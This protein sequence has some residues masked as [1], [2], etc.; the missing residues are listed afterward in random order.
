MEFAWT[1]DFLGGWI[2]FRY[3]ILND[4]EIESFST[5]TRMFF[6]EATE[7]SQELQQHLSAPACR[8]RVEAF[9]HSMSTGAGGIAWNGSL[10]FCCP[11]HVVILHIWRNSWIFSPNGSTQSHCCCLLKGFQR[12]THP[13]PISS[14]HVRGRRETTGPKEY[15][16]I[17][18]HTKKLICTTCECAQATA[19]CV[20]LP[21][22]PILV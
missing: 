5:K 15:T 12:H 7:Q 1:W 3:T 18:T 17:V 14:E 11:G 19:K 9:G 2:A 16:P 6:S 22:K 13:R 21:L 8:C 20:Q 10:W 4:I